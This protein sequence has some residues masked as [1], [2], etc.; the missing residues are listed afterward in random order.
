MSRRADL[1]WMKNIEEGGKEI[2][3]ELEQKYQIRRREKHPGVKE[4]NQRVTNTAA[5]TKHTETELVSTMRTSSI[6]QKKFKQSFIGIEQ[7]SVLLSETNVNGF[8][9]F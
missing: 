4:S 9:D 8:F 3:L 7:K 6:R 2:T 1:A 5:K